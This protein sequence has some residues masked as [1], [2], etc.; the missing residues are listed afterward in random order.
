MNWYSFITFIYLILPYFPMVLWRN[1]SSH[2]TD[3]FWIGEK[4]FLVLTWVEQHFFFPTWT[5]PVDQSTHNQCDTHPVMSNVRDY[6]KMWNHVCLCSSASRSLHS[7]LLLHKTFW[8][9]SKVYIK[10]PEKILASRK[11]VRATEIKSTVHLR[12]SSVLR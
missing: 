11:P 2:T 5:F 10:I 6:F 7:L 8:K 12:V 3:S 4:G 1:R 9:S